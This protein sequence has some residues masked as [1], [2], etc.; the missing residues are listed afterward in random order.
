M[1]SKEERRQELV[2]IARDV[3]LRFGFRKTTLDD[4]ANA[5]GM[6]KSSLY[7]YFESKEEWFRAA[8]WSIQDENIEVWADVLFGSDTLLESLHGM[9]ESAKERL[10]LFEPHFADFFFEV[11]AFLPIIKDIL[12]K[13][14]KKFH[15][16]IVKRLLYAVEQGEYDEMPAEEV[17]D[18]LQ[19]VL[20]HSLELHRNDHKLCL[21]D[22]GA[23]RY[24]ELLLSPYKKHV[25]HK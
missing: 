23:S 20:H 7:H 8:V 25:I 6:T 1:A 10:Q 14:N 11:Q 12:E 18:M 15:D 9:L 2:E 4:L 16:I 22:G 24:F 17:A 13:Q 19:L 5:M 21:L 3:F